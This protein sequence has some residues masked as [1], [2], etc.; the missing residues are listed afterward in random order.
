M[1][2]SFQAKILPVYTDAKGNIRVKYGGKLFSPSEIDI[3]DLCKRKWAWRYL[4]KIYPPPNKSA[5]LGLDNHDE[6]ED[7]VKEKKV[8]QSDILIPALE[9]FPLPG[10]N[11]IAERMIG[12]EIT[13]DGETFAFHGKIDVTD[14]NFKVPRYYDLKT[15]GD[16]KW[17][18]SKEDLE[19]D[20]QTTIYGLAI[21]VEADADSVTAKWVYARTNKPYKA[22]P[23][24]LDLTKEQILNTLKEK[25]L[26]LAREIN[27]LLEEKPLAKEVTPDFTS[28]SAFGGC[29]HQE[30]CDATAKQKFMAIMKQ[31]S[32][33]KNKERKLKLV[34]DTQSGEDE[35]PTAKEKM[36]ALLAKKKGKEAAKEA[37]E[38]VEKVP[39]QATGGINP[40]DAAPEKSEKNDDTPP[41]VEVKAEASEKTKKKRGRPKKTESASNGS[42]GNTEEESAGP[43]ILYVDCFIAKGSQKVKD[44]D[45]IVAPV[46]NELEKEFGIADYR[47]MQYSQGSAT[48]AA[49]LKEALKSR[50][51]VFNVFTDTVDREVLAVLIE[52]AD[53]VIRAKR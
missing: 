52:R 15:T 46:R 48:L 32:V 40:P 35:M 36:E 27:Q 37:V 44:A 42:N 2:I 24:E 12:V 6:L 1:G 34:K 50:V 9:H 25:I 21:L 38:K 10:D 18:K 45:E 5:Q 8:P 31:A 33:R 7:Y 11:I 20:S 3:F 29:P 51:G 39:V 28:C 17:A 49:G 43:F 16:F 4:A 26:P 14:Q 19:E 47:L 22:H 41:E 13:I 30:R 53:M 23:V